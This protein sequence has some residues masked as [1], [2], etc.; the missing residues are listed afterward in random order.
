MSTPGPSVHE[1]ALSVD[2][3]KLEGEHRNNLSLSGDN[4]QNRI[5]ETARIL[6]SDESPEKLDDKKQEQVRKNAEL[7]SD[8]ENQDKLDLATQ[9]LVDQNLAAFQ[10]NANILL[11]E[12]LEDLGDATEGKS[13]SE[14]DLKEYIH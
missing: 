11:D 8:P 7:L 13:P 6:L 10:K 14:H 5:Q 1:V 4:D 9:I 2:G 3:L 12:H